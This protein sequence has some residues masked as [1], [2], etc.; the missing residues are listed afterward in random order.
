MNDVALIA[1]LCLSS[2][3]IHHIYIDLSQ[4]VYIYTSEE[5]F[6]AVELKKCKAVSIV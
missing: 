3:H 2:T 5:L 6:Y 1:R 4:T